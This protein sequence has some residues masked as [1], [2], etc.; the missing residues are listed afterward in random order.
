MRL[1]PV[2]LVSLLLAIPAQAE[3]LTIDR[4]VASPSLSGAA[5]R[6]VHFSPDGRMVAY[7]ERAESDAS[8]RDLWAYDLA[9]GKAV[10][11][12]DSAEFVAA[13]ESEAERARRE[14]QRIAETGVTE[15]VWDQQ[16]KAV[17][18]PKSGDIWLKPLDGPVRRMTSTEAPETD[19]KFSPDGRRIAYVRDGNLYVMDIASGVEKPITRDGG[20][21]VRNGEAEFVAQEEMGRQTGYWWSRDGSH[22]A[23]AR[24]DERAVPLVNRYDYGPDGVMV[25]PQRYPFAGGANVAVRLLVAAVEG[26]GAPVEIDLGTEADIYLAR[27]AW[28]PDGGLAVQRMSR[29]QK[30][31]DLLFADAATGR[32]RVALSETAATWVDLH[33]DLR[34]LKDGRFIW[35]SEASGYRHLYLHDVDGQRLYPLTSGEW[36]VDDLAGLDEEAG[37]ILFNGFRDGPTERHVYRV[38]LDGS[39]AATPERI[40]REEGWHGAV[41]AEKGGAWLD[42]FSSAIQPPQLSLRAP[43]GALRHW[44]QENRLDKDHPYFPYLDAHIA[45]EFGTLKAEDGTDLQWAM[46]KPKG[47]DAAHKAPAIVYTY[48][49]PTA[50]VVKKQ[51]G[52]RTQLFLQVLAQSGYVVFMVDNRGTPARGKAFLD[53][54]HNAFGT[55]ENDDQAAGAAY[56]KR[57]DFVDGERIGIYGHSYGGYNTL[58]ALIRHPEMFAAGVSAA[59]VT[60]WR[61]YDTHYTE[62]FIGKPDGA[63]GIY[64]KADATKL[65]ARLTRPL[66]LIHGMADD[67]VFLDNSVRMAAA[68]Q[69]ERKPF[70]MMFYPGERHGFYDP[71]MA[72]HYLLQAK[73][74]FDRTLQAGR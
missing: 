63:G 41:V 53:K 59:P 5:P 68:L 14:R 57:L 56:L 42:S 3:N 6:G 22:I 33:D 25:V 32:T 29:D 7:L 43:D 24:I 49:G 36:P 50:Q 38:R 71:D 19:P 1:L 39:D 11:L 9:T 16:G 67:N 73:D 62:R 46:L 20:G 17:L 54:I 10:M 64:E 30:R 61:L 72:A 58:M 55:V 70:D 23:F 31:L 74:F 13:P 15:Y 21:T 4:L 44:L 12:L 26:D 47:V 48:G 52:G 45:P 18:V 8:R 37:F 34:F 66:L 28:K 27:V 65:A 40:S 69:H 51:W 2:A 60:D 35:S